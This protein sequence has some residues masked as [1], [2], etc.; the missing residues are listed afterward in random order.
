MEYV[1]LPL[2]LIIG[3]AAGLVLLVLYVHSRITQLSE[4][5]KRLTDQQRQHVEWNT[6]LEKLTD[7][8]GQKIDMVNGLVM[9]LADL[10]QRLTIECEE[11]DKRGRYTTLIVNK[12]GDMFCDLAARLEALE[13]AAGT[14]TADGEIM[15]E[16][17]VIEADEVTL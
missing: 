15:L 11:V 7:L 3:M 16:A 14:T 2:P 6:R 8:H 4:A 10:T 13:R 17:R 1:T 12:Q 9:K 5:A